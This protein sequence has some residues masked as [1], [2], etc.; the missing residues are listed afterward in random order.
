[1]LPRGALYTLQYTLTSK[2]VAHLSRLLL[3]T[4]TNYFHFLHS[5]EKDRQGWQAAGENSHGAVTE[6]DT[7]IC[8]LPPPR[9]NLQSQKVYS[10]SIYHD[11]R[12]TFPNDVFSHKPAGV[13]LIVF[14]SLQWQLN[15]LMFKVNV[16]F[17]YKMRLW[18]SWRV[19]FTVYINSLL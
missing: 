6:A 17:L 2:D 10:T 9:E 14:T 16:Y 11:F 3:L 18:V 8:R 13:K 12:L 7:H 5:R 19:S 15:H 1:M 4:F